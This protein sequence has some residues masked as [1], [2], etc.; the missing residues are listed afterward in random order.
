M[1]TTELTEKSEVPLA[2]P[3]SLQCGQKSPFDG[4]SEAW[5]RL[6]LCP[7]GGHSTP[8]PLTRVQLCH[9]A[10][11]AAAMVSDWGLEPQGN[12]GAC[13][14]HGSQLEAS[15]SVVSLCGGW[16]VSDPRALDSR[17]PF[18]SLAHEV[19]LG[20]RNNHCHSSTHLRQIPT[21][22]LNPQFYANIPHAL[23]NPNFLA[24]NT[25]SL[26]LL[27]LGMKQEIKQRQKGP[28]Q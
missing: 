1:S 18:S 23:Q 24:Q 6:G 3:K 28:Y 4:R 19:S 7:Q 16:Q 13:H 17:T 20:V 2:S 5:L 8:P 26:R 15:S 22:Q 27:Q 14:Q 21:P 12:G 10:V 11:P 9:L 25:H